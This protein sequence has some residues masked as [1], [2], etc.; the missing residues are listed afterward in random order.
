VTGYSSYLHPYDKNGDYVIGI[1]MEA[2][3]RGRTRGVK[4]AL[5]DATD[6]EN[7]KELAKYEVNEGLKGWSSSDT[8][9]DHKAFLFDKKRN[10]L[11]MPVSYTVSNGL[12]ERGFTK[13][14]YW[15]GAYVFDIS[16]EGIELRGKI[17]HE[18]KDVEE[19]NEW[20]WY[21][22]GNYVKRSLFMDDV[23]YTV[24]D[25]MIKA[26]DLAKDLEGINQVDISFDDNYYPYARGGAGI[27]E[28]A[29]AFSEGE[30]VDSVDVSV[31][32]EAKGIPNLN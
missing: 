13:Y 3:E 22:G 7:P 19:G 32:V 29:V 24:S 4:I 25:K 20:R 15:Q 26:N 17:T 16:L 30:E 11:V 10:L 1:G 8:L 2:D 9:Y 21:G 12:N 5:F 14:G 28:E 27:I 6:V 18:S 23:L 31:S